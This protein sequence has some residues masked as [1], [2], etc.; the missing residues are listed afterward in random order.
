MPVKV[1]I[2]T[3]IGTDV[4]DAIA[5]AFATRLVQLEI[6][7]ITTVYGPTDKRARLLGKLLHVLGRDD[8][9]FAPGRQL[10]LGL[11]SEERGQ[12]I[13]NEIP[14]QYPF[15]RP[16]DPVREPS[17]A[18]A[19]ELLSRV[20]GE[21]PNEVWLVT[22]GPMTNAAALRRGL[23]DTAKKLKGIVCMGG[24]PHR[25]YREY[26]VGSD[27]EA[28]SEVFRSGLLRFQATFDAP[29]TFAG[30]ID[31]WGDIVHTPGKGGEKTQS[32]RIDHRSS[33]LKRFH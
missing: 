31:L 12:A 17:C 25:E 19:D 4:D 8:I 22:I 32:N 11:V 3:D 21:N 1:I 33:I 27:P 26:N 6:R 14:N 13:L 5:I 10:P 15:V 9:P 24:E 28:A 30:S 29:V 2:D 16:E 20:I 18:S 23:P 7:A